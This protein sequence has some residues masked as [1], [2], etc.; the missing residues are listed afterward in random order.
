ME[1]N[2]KL[3]QLSF[4]SYQ[5]GLNLF[6]C[7]VSLIGDYPEI[8]FKEPLLFKGKKTVLDK[9]R[10][11]RNAVLLGIYLQHT[12]IDNLTDHAFEISENA[13]FSYLTIEHP[14]TT[15][16]ERFATTQRL[17][18][19]KMCVL[20]DILSKKHPLHVGCPDLPQDGSISDNEFYRYSIWLIENSM[21]VPSCYS[22]IMFVSETVA[23]LVAWFTSTEK[24]IHASDYDL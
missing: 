19:T 15:P 2:N 9:H 11:K 4:L 5:R 1:T 14:T 21:P 6:N 17:V 24:E 16:E 22:D 7:M 20:D 18:K 23:C 12:L 3:Y 10:L 13:I 8:T